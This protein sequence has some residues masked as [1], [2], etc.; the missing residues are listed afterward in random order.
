MKKTL[1]LLLFF[2]TIG[3][4]T[5]A[6]TSCSDNG[7]VPTSS[8]KGGNGNQ[9]SGD[10]FQEEDTLQVSYS[11]NKTE[12]KLVAFVDV[13]NNTTKIPEHLDSFDVN[14]T[15]SFG[16]IEFKGISYLNGFWGNYTADYNDCSISITN[17]NLTYIY[18]FYDAKLYWDAVSIA[19]TFTLTVDTLKLFY[20]N[21]DNYLLFSKI[22]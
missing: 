3:L 18:E 6:I 15:L 8:P 16:I 7:I 22:E 4:I 9:Q 17:F 2:A 10:L 11:L 5:I 1:N 19:E 14:Y 13:A 12:W 20:N 21:G